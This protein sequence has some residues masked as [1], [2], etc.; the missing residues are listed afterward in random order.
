MGKFL[1]AIYALAVVSVMSGFVLAIVGP[2]RPNEREQLL[3]RQ[4]IGREA[5]RRGG[6]TIK[7]TGK[8]IRPRSLNGPPAR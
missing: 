2:I 1:Y 8:P 6:G 5:L 7:G 4:F 3:P